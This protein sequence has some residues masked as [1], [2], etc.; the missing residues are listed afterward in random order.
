MKKH[1]AVLLSAYTGFLLTKSFADVHAF[2]EKTLERPVFTHELAS[3]R[4]LS[5]LMIKLRPQI[6]ALVANEEDD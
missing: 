1:E 6:E 3:E 2:I 5:E 4:V